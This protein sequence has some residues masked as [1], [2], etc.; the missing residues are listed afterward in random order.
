MGANGS[1]VVAEL[2]IA[3]V[4]CFL[5]C[6]SRQERGEQLLGD[7]GRPLV[8][9]WLIPPAAPLC[10]VLNA[11]LCSCTLVVSVMSCRWVLH[12]A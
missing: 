5:G 3:R 8:A 12:D 6:S 1:C 4:V 11:E 2:R 9:G 10:A 7:R